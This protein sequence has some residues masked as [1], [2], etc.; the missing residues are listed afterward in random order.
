M[1][2]KWQHK[3]ML[4][5][6]MILQYDEK[7]TVNVNGIHKNGQRPS[8]Q[9]ESGMAERN[10]EKGKRL[11]G[12]AS[13]RDVRGIPAQAREPF[14]NLALNNTK[15]VE[16]QPGKEQDSGLSLFLLDLSDILRDL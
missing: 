1:S 13:K 2:M 12:A 14:K 4:I 16:Q 9:T 5:G 10:T 6:D 7:P 11:N 8:Y 3:A 15:G